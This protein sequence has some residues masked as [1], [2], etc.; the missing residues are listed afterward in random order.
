M[1]GLYLISYA[2][3]RFL[4]ELFRG[5]YRAAGTPL[6]SQPVAGVFTPGQTASFLVL[7][8]GV[9]IYLYCRKTQP[10]V[11]RPMASA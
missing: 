4:V 9:G 5:D 11:S 10:P 2:F 6:I 8:A 3:I 1:T 7:A